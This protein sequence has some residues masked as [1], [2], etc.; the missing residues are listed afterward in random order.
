MFE[1]GIDS[2]ARDILT[3]KLNQNTVLLCAKLSPL[4]LLYQRRE[5]SAISSLQISDLLDNRKVS[6]KYIF[7]GSLF[8]I[9][10]HFT[11]CVYVTR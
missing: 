3:V 9:V 11:S 4:A 10:L 8:E 5:T 6:D 7:K 1:G 2:M